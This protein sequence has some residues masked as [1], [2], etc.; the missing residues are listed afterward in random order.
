MPTL[1]RVWTRQDFEIDIYI[2]YSLVLRIYVY[3]SFN[4]TCNWKQFTVIMPMKSM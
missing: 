1:G 4:V 3:T 2:L